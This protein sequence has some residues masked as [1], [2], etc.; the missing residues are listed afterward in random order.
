L[1]KEQCKDSVEGRKIGGW[2]L[3][4]VFCLILY[5]LRLLFSIIL[6]LYMI[7][8]VYN[9]HSSDINSFRGMMT[10]TI[11]KLMIIPF[12]VAILYKFFKLNRDLP[13]LM[14]IF[15]IFNCIASIINSIVFAYIS[16]YL[17]VFTELAL[18][19]PT[20]SI[21]ITIAL[22]CYFARSIRVKET[23]IK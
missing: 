4:I 23:F 20:I 16:G 21:I 11:I 1:V 17:F 8:S 18:I 3:I 22:L 6:N 10:I 15:L 19:S 13:R 9:P 2:L 14:A 7:I 12:L 5:A